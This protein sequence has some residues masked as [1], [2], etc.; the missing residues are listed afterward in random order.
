MLE[1]YKKQK[2][3]DEVTI[4]VKGELDISTVN[5]FINEC[6]KLEG[7]TLV[8]LNLA[9]L[10]FIDSTGI[11]AILELI[12]L[13]KEKHIQLKIIES[14]QDIKDIFDTMGIMRVLEAIQRGDM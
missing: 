11:G 2:S 4:F 9:N 5:H 6:K 3:N 8:N 7:V 14:N 12:Y 1:V 10:A 13:S